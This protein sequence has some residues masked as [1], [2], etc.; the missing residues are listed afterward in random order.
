MVKFLLFKFVMLRISLSH[1]HESNHLRK[2]NAMCMCVCEHTWCTQR[3]QRAAF[4]V[5]TSVPPQDRL[6][7]LA[8]VYGRPA[9][10][11]VP[12]WPCW[13]SRRTLLYLIARGY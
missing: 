3:C 10:L 4:S 7:V 2:K 9:G 6:S 13:D 8:A 11:G 1:R 5:G 12:L